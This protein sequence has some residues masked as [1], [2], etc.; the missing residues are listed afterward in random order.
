ML[1]ICLDMGLSAFASFLEFLDGFN[2]NM[3]TAVLL[4]HGGWR[5]LLT[6]KKG[7]LD[8]QC[9]RHG[10]DHNNNVNSLTPSAQISW[11]LST[12][13]EQSS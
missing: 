3:L 6:P 9:S 1:Q 13:N 12:T 7:I 10:N 2:E 4:G 11:L 8:Y 5:L